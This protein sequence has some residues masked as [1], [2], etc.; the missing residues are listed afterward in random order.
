MSQDRV[1]Q[2]ARPLYEFTELGEERKKEMVRRGVLVLRLTTVV[3][4]GQV[5]RCVWFVQRTGWG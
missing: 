2:L 1:L 5:V 3:W 4:P